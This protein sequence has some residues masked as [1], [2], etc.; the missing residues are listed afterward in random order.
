[1]SASLLEFSLVIECRG[2]SVFQGLDKFVSK[3]DIDKSEFEKYCI[4]CHNVYVN[5][6]LGLFVKVLLAKSGIATQHGSA[7][8]VELHYSLE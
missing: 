7:L 3:I 2:F 4:A 6:I 1:M 5:F 8:G